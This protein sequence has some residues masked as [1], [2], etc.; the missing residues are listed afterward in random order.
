MTRPVLIA[1][2]L[3]APT[4]LSAATVEI[5]SGPILVGPGETAGGGAQVRSF[6]LVAPDMSSNITWT[7][8][9]NTT[10]FVEHEQKQ[11][12]E[13]KFDAP[14]PNET[15]TRT[16]QFEHKDGP[17]PHGSTTTVRG[18]GTGEI[19]VTT[20]GDGNILQS[21]TVNVVLT[22]IGTLG[23]VPNSGTT[24]VHVN[25]H[26]FGEAKDPMIVT[27]TQ[28]AAAGLSA[29]LADVFFGFAL[30]QLDISG[31]IP[32]F[33]QFST[34]S[35]VWSV[36]MGGVTTTVLSLAFSAAGEGTVTGSPDATIF[37][38]DGLNSLPPSDLT[39]AISVD[40]IKALL[41]ADI[42]P[43]NRLDTPLFFGALIRDAFT[44]DDS[45][46]GLEAF[47]VTGDATASEPAFKTGYVPLPPAAAG[48]MLGLAALGALAR[49]RSRPVGMP[50]S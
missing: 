18:S 35:A 46:L 3:C 9:K 43:D 17:G 21:G 50:A 29:G 38:L 40:A 20:D 37:Q 12:T 36:V 11:K 28:L 41:L 10:D 44:F 2:L 27:G 34:A 39:T 49:R 31:G 8:G 48:L 5:T 45:D 13:L 15:A 6:Q 16:L 7:A 30:H 42:L 23:Y 1:A 22:A 19:E 14:S 24:P 26:A 33:G 25:Y 47:R 32:G 4:H